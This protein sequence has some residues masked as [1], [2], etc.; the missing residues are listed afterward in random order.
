MNLNYQ[1]SLGFEK[2]MANIIIAFLSSSI[3]EMYRQWVSDGRNIPIEDMINTT[4]Q[5][6]S[7]GISSLRK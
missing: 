4:S 5:L 2:N 7:K 3:L 1:T 6:I